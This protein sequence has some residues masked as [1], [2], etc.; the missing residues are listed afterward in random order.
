MFSYSFASSITKFTVSI[1]NLVDRPPHSPFQKSF[2]ILFSEIYCSHSRKMSLKLSNTIILIALNGFGFP[3]QI[4]RPV[5]T[6]CFTKRTKSK[7]A[8][9]D[10]AGR[11]MARYE[12]DASL[13]L[14]SC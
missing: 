2:F 8:F 14:D 10:S 13:V 3:E 9:R 7:H 12:H 1:K 6:Q 5:R 11:E 4:V